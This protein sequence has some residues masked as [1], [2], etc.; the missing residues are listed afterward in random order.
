MSSE[1]D[2]NELIGRPY[3]L[4]SNPPLTF[5]CFSLVEYV[6]RI[7]FGLTTPVPYA[8]ESFIAPSDVPRVWI[9]VEHMDVWQPADVPRDGDI[10]KLER[11]HVG[12]YL[13]GAVMHAWKSPNY[14]GVIVTNM[15]LIRRI[16]PICKFL[17]LAQ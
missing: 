12:V 3:A 13:H 14:N 11:R 2:P 16:F 1:M 7:Y 10:V 8:V 6:R 5:D 17:R 4:P 15:R 9:R